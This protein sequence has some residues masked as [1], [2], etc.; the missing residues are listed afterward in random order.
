MDV[1]T[2]NHL[3]N[4]IGR[5]STNQIE[6]FIRQSY[7]KEYHQRYQKHFS[8]LGRQ[9]NA[10]EREMTSRLLYGPTSPGD[11]AR[12]IYPNFYPSL[13]FIPEIIPKEKV[14]NPFKV[15]NTMQQK[16]LKMNF[17]SKSCRH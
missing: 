2:F 7:I 4:K 8:Y 16:K 11:I 12:F 14:F 1:F 10:K 13:A 3:I 15:I 5:D 9:G 6:T 17:K